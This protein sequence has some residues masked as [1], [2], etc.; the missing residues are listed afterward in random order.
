VLRARGD[1]RRV[2][3]RV[4]GARSTERVHHRRGAPRAVGACGAGIAT[5]G[6]QY[7][8]AL[9]VG[10]RAA[11][12]PATFALCLLASVRAC[13]RPAAAVGCTLQPLHAAAAH[14]AASGACTSSGPGCAPYTPPLKR[15]TWEY[16][17]APAALTRQRMSVSL[18]RRPGRS[19]RTSHGRQGSSCSA[20]GS[21]RWTW[22]RGRTR[23]R[24]A[25]LNS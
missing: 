14:G 8:A 23:R 12:T 11:A 16:E 18:A 2:R 20:R 1:S 15:Q 22:A 5:D 4:T 21:T 19:H 17:T 13:T 10:A 24:R 6:R 3:A 7:D 25:I 9:G